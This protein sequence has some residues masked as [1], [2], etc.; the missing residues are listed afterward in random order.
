MVNTKFKRV[1]PVI[2]TASMLSISGCGKLDTNTELELIKAESMK[3]Y[4]LTIKLNS[5]GSDR[6]IRLNGYEMDDPEIGEDTRIHTEIF[7]KNSAD[8]DYDY[9]TTIE[10]YKNDKYINIK[11]LLNKLYSIEELAD[12]QNI[13][14]DTDKEYVVYNDEYLKSTF[15]TYL[16]NNPNLSNASK[17]R[18]ITEKETAY[19]VKD[20]AS[21]RTQSKLID[22]TK[23]LSKLSDMTSF[24][25]TNTKADMVSSFN[26]LYNM[27]SSY[28]S[29]SY[30]FGTYITT[31]KGD[32]AISYVNDLNNLA[33]DGSFVQNIFGS[34]FDTDFGAYILE[35]SADKVN[36]G[37][38]VYFTDLLNEASE[39][40]VVEFRTADAGLFKKEQGVY[41][42][43]ST[44]GTNGIEI[45]YH[46]GQE[47]SEE[48]MNNYFKIPNNTMTS[49][50]FFKSIAIKYLDN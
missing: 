28:G 49:T 13:F 1:I 31:L 26:N 38:S 48:D 12:Y 45:L 32:E 41:A 27:T 5:K 42:K 50:D 22:N 21:L 36:N 6:Y 37:F 18:V 16:D 39:D 14:G 17:P 8:A 7:T 15:E 33:S 35:K 4:D 44:N 23:E 30:R 9:V 24:V 19:G 11:A 29:T 25:N 3:K 46:G 10:E 2:I 43:I 20:D 40:A 34:L 47:I